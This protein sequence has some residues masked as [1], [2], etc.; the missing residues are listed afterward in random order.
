MLGLQGLQGLRCLLLLLLRKGS[1]SFLRNRSQL[2]LVA[3]RLRLGRVTSKSSASRHSLKWL[4]WWWR[5]LL[6]L[7][8]RLPKWI[9][10]ALCLI[11]RSI[12]GRL[13]ISSCQ[14]LLLNRLGLLLD[15]LGLLLEASLLGI[16]RLLW[17]LLEP[18]LLV[19]YWVLLPHWLLVLLN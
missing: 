13:G 19:L 6:L 15:R 16:K 8:L 1:N 17:L 2:R 12:L 11:R 10:W 9:V 5:R 7:L 18:C 14:R 3:I 4:W